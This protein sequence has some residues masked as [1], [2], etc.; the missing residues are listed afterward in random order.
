MPASSRSRSGSQE[1]N[2]TAAY[3]AAVAAE[4]TTFFQACTTVR[5]QDRVS[6]DWRFDDE[7]TM[8]NLHDE[9][10]I[11]WTGT[12]LEVLPPGEGLVVKYDGAACPLL[13]PSCDVQQLPQPQDSGYLRIK[14]FTVQKAKQMKQTPY[15]RDRAGNQMNREG[16]E[17][18]NQEQDAR[19]TL[20]RREGREY[21]L[22]MHD[23]DNTLPF[24]TMTNHDTPRHTTTYHTQHL[25]TLARMYAYFGDHGEIQLKNALRETYK[26][27]PLRHVH[28]D[29]VITQLAAWVSRCKN[30]EEVEDDLGYSLMV[31]VQVAAA[32]AEG[33][34]PASM[35]MKLEKEYL[36]D[37]PYLVAKAGASRISISNA[38]KNGRY[39]GPQAWARG[40]QV[41]NAS[42]TAPRCQLCKRTNH[43]TESCWFRH[44]SAQFQHPGP[45]PGPQRYQQHQ[46]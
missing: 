9:N 13:D 22:Q 31:D 14:N 4:R 29:K 27:D 19:G 43:T 7:C 25:F 46:L 42:A 18:E 38:A 28:R 10:F 11:R 8:E 39:R 17:Y 26:V 30:V 12:V 24:H 20:M 2:V 15:K 3:T 35:R 16:R 32:A 41:T 45:R 36:G 23:E 5:P 33:V 37:S 40:P 1:R 34:D 6:F 44:R 21:E